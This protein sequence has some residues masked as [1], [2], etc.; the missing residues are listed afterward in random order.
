MKKKSEPGIMVLQIHN[1]KVKKDILIH[2]SYS[3]CPSKKLTTTNAIA[4]KE[5]HRL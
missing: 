1:S 4:G 2:L 5:N 3:S